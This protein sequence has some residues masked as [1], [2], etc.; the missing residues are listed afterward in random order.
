[1]STFTAVGRTA[2][3][4]NLGPDH[5]A[6]FFDYTTNDTQS[7]LGKTA[8]AALATPYEDFRTVIPDVLT[9]LPTSATTY[10]DTVSQL[11]IDR[12]TDNR[13]VLLGDAAWCVSLFAATAPP[14]P[15][16]APTSSPPPSTSR[17][18]RPRCGPGRP[19]CDQRQQ[20]ASDA[21]AATRACMHPRTGSV[22]SPVTFR[23]VPPCVPPV[24]QLI[25]HQLR[26]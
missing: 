19:S 20:R 3:I 8:F 23:C 1:M 21:A 10:F 13:V 25:R 16:P 26:A 7:E 4:A 17:T 15:W 24:R 11:V 18:S 14:W 22:C 6:A 5:R 9:Q 12:W 2:T